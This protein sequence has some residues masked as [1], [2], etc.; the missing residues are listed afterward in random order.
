MGEDE[1]NTSFEC[2]RCEGTQQSHSGCILRALLGGRYAAGTCPTCAAP[3]ATTVSTLQCRSLEGVAKRGRSEWVA[4]RFMATAEAAEA[5]GAMEVGLVDKPSP[6]A[7]PMLSSFVASPSHRGNNS[8]LWVACTLDGI[9]FREFVAPTQKVSPQG[10]GFAGKLGV[11]FRELFLFP[12]IALAK[13]A[14]PVFGLAGL[15]E[16]ALGL[17]DSF[18]F[19]LLWAL[20]T[21]QPDE[22]ALDC[23]DGDLLST[24][25][26][27][28]NLLRSINREVLHPLPA[29]VARYA[30]DPRPLLVISAAAHSNPTA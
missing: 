12:E 3:A 26:A 11:L 14:Q 1:D 8:H 6:P 9:S 15:R 19:R 4:E 16:Y 18:S 24:L 13:N 7:L 25:V 5:D 2:E 20:S 29:F 27:Y 28:S 30:L 17:K 21:G 22:P 10:G 23:D